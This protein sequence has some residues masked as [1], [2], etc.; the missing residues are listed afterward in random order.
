MLAHWGQ[1][2]QPIPQDCCGSGPGDVQIVNLGSSNFDVGNT[3]NFAPFPQARS[4]FWNI[5]IASGTVTDTDSDDLLDPWELTY[6]ADLTILNGKGAG[7]GPGAGTGDFDGDGLL[8]KDEQSRG[9]NPVLADTDGDTLSDS[10][11]LAGAGLRPATDPKKPDTDNDGLSDS[12]ETNDGTFN[13]PTDTGTD[14]TKADTDDDALADNVETNDGTFK[15]PTDTGT[16]PL[17]ADTDGDGRSD[18]AE[19]SLETNP[20]DPNDPPPLSGNVIGNDLTRLPV[21]LP[22]GDTAG[23]ALIIDG[24]HGPEFI[25]PA[26]G[27]VL[28]KMTILNDPD[29]TP[30]PTDLLVLRPDG[31]GGF[32]VIHRVTIGPDDDPPTTSGTT[33]YPLADLEVQAGDLL[34]H[35]GDGAQPIPADCCGNGP[36]DIQINVPSENVDVGN[37][38]SFGPFPQ[39]RDYFYNVTLG[40]GQPLAFTNIVRNAAAGTVDVTWVSSIGKTYRMEYSDDLIAWIE[41]TDS[42]PEGGATSDRTTYQFKDIPPDSQKRFF[43]AKAE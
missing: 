30:E 37:T 27:G 40:S 12:A 5:T 38:I 6:V 3:V 42:Y 28:T 33:D 18:G 25:I 34:A 29:E 15:S 16:N 35:W 23:G 36:S 17:V 31:A 41:T 26:G 14:P 24:F 20:N 39:K 7:P 19:V 11:E 9:T 43:K 8:D 4:Y 13:S 1:G 22:D 21:G 2:H 10:A 32:T